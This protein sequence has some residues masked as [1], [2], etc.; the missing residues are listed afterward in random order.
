MLIRV[1]ALIGLFIMASLPA[2]MA[3]QMSPL[4]FSLTYLDR[5]K[6]KDEEA[7]LTEP[8]GL[9]LARD[10]DALWTISDDEKR[11]FKSLS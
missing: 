1:I 6:I 9:A 5:F 3:A 2:T 7:G 4:S 10:D 11:I 8:S